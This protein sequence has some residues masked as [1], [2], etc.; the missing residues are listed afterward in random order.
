MKKTKKLR[1]N[2]K[3]GGKNK[4]CKTKCKKIFLNEIKNDN[5]Y[6]IMEKFAPY[7]FTKKNIVEEQANLVL[8]DKDIQN[9]S[10]FKN[11]VKNCKNN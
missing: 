3:K 7:F 10:E 5:R 6:K 2:K 9:D 4:N 11:C 8:D 1:N